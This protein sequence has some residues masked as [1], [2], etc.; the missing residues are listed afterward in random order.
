VALG[1]ELAGRPG[2]IEMVSCEEVD[3]ALGSNEDDSEAERKTDPDDG[4]AYSLEELKSKY[5][6]I[7]S[8]HELLEYFHTTCREI[9]DPEQRDLKNGVDPHACFDEGL[10]EKDRGKDAYAKGKYEEAVTAW[11]MAR[12]T[13][14]HIVER[15]LFKDNP[16]KLAE[17]K[18]LQVLINLN[19]AQGCLKNGQFQQAISHANKV[20]EVEPRNEKALH[21]KAAALIDASMYNKAREVLNTLLEVDPNNASAKKMLNDVARKVAMA[22]KSAKRVSRA[23]MG[24][25]DRDPRT[26]LT[27]KEWG[28][29]EAS[30]LLERVLSTDVAAHLQ[31]LRV[32]RM[33]CRRCQRRRRD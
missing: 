14:K 7:Y 13:F 27:W 19:L 1:I 9:E 32:V 10:Q 33:L 29:R 25:M 18:Q 8:E 17:V 15:D 11:C 2:V 23:M 4:V 28:Q 24:G 22:A 12:G 30:V 16:A 21:R 26:G 20:L 3:Q 6:G 5:D 31:E